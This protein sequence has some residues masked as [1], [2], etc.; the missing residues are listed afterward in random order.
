MR[1]ETIEIQQNS[2][3]QVIRLPEEF[4]IDDNKVYLKKTGNT[5]QVIPFHNPWENFF[6]SLADF[7]PDFMERNQPQEQNRESFD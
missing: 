3:D 2:N 6:E 1:I 5:I 7:T 4:R